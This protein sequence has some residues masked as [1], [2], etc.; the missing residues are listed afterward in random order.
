MKIDTRETELVGKWIVKNGQVH[1]DSI[2]ER[3][4]CLTSTHLRKCAVSKQWGAWEILYQ[5]PDDGRY[6]E[7]TY[8]QSDMHGGGPPALKC[9]SKELAKAKFGD[10]VQ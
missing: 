9:I 7:Q 6:L 10:D 1:G 3:I 2:C 8:P 4:Q 5:D